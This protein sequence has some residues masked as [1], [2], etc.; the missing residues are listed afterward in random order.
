MSKSRYKNDPFTDD[1]LMKT[2]RSIDISKMID[3]IVDLEIIQKKSRA[4]KINEKKN[5]DSKIKDE[6]KIHINPIFNNKFID[7]ENNSSQKKKDNNNKDINNK[8]KDKKENN[9]NNDL[10]KNNNNN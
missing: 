6:Q 5:N 7:L 10:I 9:N 8:E 3:E 2:L 1:A 4:Y